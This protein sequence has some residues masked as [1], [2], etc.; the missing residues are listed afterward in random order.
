MV[1]LGEIIVI[2]FLKPTDAARTERKEEEEEEEIKE[3]NTSFQP[4]RLRRTD[5]TRGKNK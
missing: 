4:L 2:C 3:W 5:C 1:R